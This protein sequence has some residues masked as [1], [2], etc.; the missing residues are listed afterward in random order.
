MA[1]PAEEP[2]QAP[3]EAAEPEATPADAPVSDE[4]AAPAETAEGAAPATD[5]KPELPIP[6]YT[7]AK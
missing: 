5:K 6:A 3:A 4:G 2:P 7:P 1:D